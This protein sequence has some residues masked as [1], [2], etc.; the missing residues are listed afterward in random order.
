MRIYF[1]KIKPNFSF[2]TIEES[3]FPIMNLPPID[4][5]I[6]KNTYMAMFYKRLT[7]SKV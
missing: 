1:D 4:T 3:K 2:H 6:K 7:C 5:K